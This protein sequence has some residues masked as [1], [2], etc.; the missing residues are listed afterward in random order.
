MGCASLVPGNAGS[1]APRKQLRRGAITAK[2]IS[3]KN[4]R[5][6]KKTQRPSKNPHRAKVILNFAAR[7]A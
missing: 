7:W 1:L 3:A 4:V 2:F 6:K 5:D